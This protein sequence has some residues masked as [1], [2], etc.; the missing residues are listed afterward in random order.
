MVSY[1]Y[2]YTLTIGRRGCTN[3]EMA[4]TSNH[5]VPPLLK[6]DIQHKNWKKRN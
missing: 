5:K 6:S 2:L 1:I 3:L 4:Q